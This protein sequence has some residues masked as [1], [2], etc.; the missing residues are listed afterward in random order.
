MS[1][2]VTL[3]TPGQEKAVRSVPGYAWM[4]PLV[5]GWPAWLEKPLPRWPHLERVLHA[6]PLNEN[7][8]PLLIGLLGEQAIVLVTIRSRTWS[9]KRVARKAGGRRVSVV[10]FGTGFCGG[11]RLKADFLHFPT[12]I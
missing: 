6:A 12:P 7:P 2:P 3:V 4:R 11:Y 10:Q 1:P 5:V 8:G 9:S